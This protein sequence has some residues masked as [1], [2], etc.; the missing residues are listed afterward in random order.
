[1]VEG[2]TKEVRIKI[3]GNPRAKIVCKVS[4]LA[5]GGGCIIAQNQGNY[6]IADD[7]ETLSDDE[8][9]QCQAWWDKIVD[10]T[11]QDVWR[12]T[13]DL[14]ERE[15]RKPREHKPPVVPGSEPM[16]GRIELQ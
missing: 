9:A 6:V 2:T 3:P 11:S 15:C 12:K 7:P 10:A 5:M 8:Q 1:M 16:P 4:L 13:R 14:Y